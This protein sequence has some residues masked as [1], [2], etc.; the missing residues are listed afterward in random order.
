MR[1]NFVATV[2]GSIKKLVV[3]PLKLFFYYNFGNVTKSC[4]PPVSCVTCLLCSY[5]QIT[6]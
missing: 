4:V 2:A 3:S 5:I 6:S 1:S